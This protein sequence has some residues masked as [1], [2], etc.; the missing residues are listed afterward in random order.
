VTTRVRERPGTRV[1][2]GARLLDSRYPEWWRRV[3]SYRIDTHSV[4]DCV[5]GQLVRARVI[6]PVEP[7][8]RWQ[9]TL[10]ALGID[11]VGGIDHG[12]DAFT[13]HTTTSYERQC[14]TLDIYWRQEVYRRAGNSHRG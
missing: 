8:T 1:A 7:G 11:T 2:R 9:D 5:L 4:R 6:R 14:A 13:T 10:E 12:F 3:Q